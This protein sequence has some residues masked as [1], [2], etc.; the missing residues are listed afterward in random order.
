[1]LES[2][3]TVFD[4]IGISSTLFRI[5]LVA[6][7][8]LPL[9]MVFH[10]IDTSILAAR[11]AD[12]LLRDTFSWGKMRIPIWGLNI[13]FT[14]LSLSLMLYFLNAM[15]SVL[16]NP[17]LFLTLAAFTPAYIT[18]ISGLVYLP[19]AARRSRDTTLRKHLLWFG[20]F[21]TFALF[22]VLLSLLPPGG[23]QAISFGASRFVAVYALYRAAR[24]LSPLSSL[25]AKA[26]T[27]AET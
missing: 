17:P 19:I 5:A 27:Q 16:L 14:L 8:Y 4:Y 6:Y 2:G 12:P 1:V 24:S 10:W 18:G 9:L 13:F 20:L 15:A 23:L 22:S 26:K 21:A 7:F 25:T 3:I 11:R